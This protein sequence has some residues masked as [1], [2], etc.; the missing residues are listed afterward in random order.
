MDSQI[1]TQKKKRKKS[2]LEK[3]GID[4]HLLEDKIH[5]TVHDIDEIK[6]QG[7]VDSVTMQNKFGSLDVLPGHINFIS[8]IKKQIVVKKESKET[9]FNIDTAVMR[10]YKNTVDVFLGADIEEIAIS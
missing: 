10:V 9:V 6:F 2:K 3:I 5:L 8:I 7:D 4:T 1:K